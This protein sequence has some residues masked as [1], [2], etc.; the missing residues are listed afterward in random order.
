MQNQ[1][2]TLLDI[3]STIVVGIA[4]LLISWAVYQQTEQ[5]A[6]ETWLETFASVHEAFWNDPAVQKSVVGLH[7]HK[8]SAL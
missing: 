2:V 8:T 1:T 7:I 3:V 5:R 4:G 6:K